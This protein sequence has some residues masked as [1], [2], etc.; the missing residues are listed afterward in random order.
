[1][2]LGLER[3]EALLERGEGLLDVHGAR[4]A[5]AARPPAR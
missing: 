4:F 2:E 1:L 5:V 3:V